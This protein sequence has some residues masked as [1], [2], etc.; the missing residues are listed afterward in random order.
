ML[1]HLP[2]LQ[3]VLPLMAAPVAALVRKRILAWAVALV[4]TWAALAIAVLLLAQVLDQGPVSYF[5]GGWAAPW[6]IEYRVDVVSAYVLVVV[7]GIG[8]I[9]MPFARLSVTREVDPKQVPLLYSAL[10]LCLTGLLGITITGD[11]FNLFVFLEI[12]SI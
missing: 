7:A 11:L 10:L 5:L 4:A 8:A 12:S 6:G 9:V 3:V 1:D 2:A